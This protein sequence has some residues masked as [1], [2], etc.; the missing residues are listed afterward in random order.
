[1]LEDSA[2]AV[3]LTDSAGRK[4]LAGCA[5]IMPVIDLGDVGCWAEESALNLDCA[6]I[7]LTPHHLAYVIYTS[8]STG[9]PKGVRSSTRMLSTS[10]AGLETRLPRRRSSE[11]FSPPRSILI[12]RCMNASYHSLLVQPS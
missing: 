11:R 2:P 10:S 7:G 3:L 12:W 1:M 6:G 8:G 5:L 4:A 9:T